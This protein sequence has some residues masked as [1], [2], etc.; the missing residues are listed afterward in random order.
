MDASKPTEESKGRGNRPGAAAPLPS[1]CRAG[2]TDDTL[3]GPAVARYDA[4][5][6]SLGTRP[7]HGDR[8]FPR[9]DVRMLVQASQTS[10]PGPGEDA[11]THSESA[12]LRAFAL[13]CE[14]TAV[15]TDAGRQNGGTP[16]GDPDPASDPDPGATRI[17]RVG[18]AWACLL[19][20]L[21]TALGPKLLDAMGGRDVW[22]GAR[23][24]HVGATFSGRLDGVPARARQILLCL[25]ERENG[26]GPLH[27]H[28]GLVP[29]ESYVLSAALRVASMPWG[30]SGEGEPLEDLGRIERFWRQQCFQ[31]WVSRREP[32]TKPEVLS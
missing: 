15:V 13:A 19:L 23:P 10:T 2:Q 1:L 16:S 17:D 28:D 26:T 27:L 9:S 29:V 22:A 25:E 21:G 8:V 32:R 11:W 18:L 12:A 5:L 20:P 24:C 3:R 30:F 4:Y 14:V 31:R 6:A 7:H